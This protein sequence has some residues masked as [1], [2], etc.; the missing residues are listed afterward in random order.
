MA[1]SEDIEARLCAYIEG[2][3]SPAEQAEIER[4][5]EAHPQHRQMIQDLIR[6]RDLVG[7][8][9]RVNA[10]EDL[11]DGLQGQLERSMLLGDG[12][13]PA[14]SASL[15]P[16]PRRLSHMAMIGV[17]CVLSVGFGSVVYY[18]LRAAFYPAQLAVAPVP[19]PPPNT[20][21]VDA[22]GA[23]AATAAN[24][25]AASTAAASDALA[26]PASD[27]TNVANASVAIATTQPTF[28]FSATQ[29]SVG[30]SSAAL[31]LSVPATEPTALATIQPATQPAPQPALG[32]SDLFA[33]PDA[34]SNPFGNPATLP[35]A[36]DLGNTLATPLLAPVQG[37]AA[38]ATQPADVPAIVF[39]TTAPV[40]ADADGQ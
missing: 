35:S 17:V 40:A 39:P 19:P 30:D 5:L 38:P 24:V 34:L 4:H 9:P 29:P 6:T 11:C 3:L 33:A 14:H 37:V 26:I 23:T 7:T 28:V 2:S 32:G 25:A 12:L 1:N 16:R 36:L 22:T 21:A 8:L 20:S 18:V 15:N 31:A 10:P 13:T 27:T